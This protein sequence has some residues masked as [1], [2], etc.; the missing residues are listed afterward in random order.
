MTVS[1]FK[2]LRDTQ[3]QIAKP[4]TIPKY[5]PGR[6]GVFTKTNGGAQSVGAKLLSVAETIASAARI[7]ARLDAD[8]LLS[9]IS[10]APTN[11]V[12]TSRSNQCGRLSQHRT[13]TRLLNNTAP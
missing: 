5:M 2:A 10:A 8:A 11:E 13:Q 9:P 4:S 1:I 3:N 6:S 7:I 12:M